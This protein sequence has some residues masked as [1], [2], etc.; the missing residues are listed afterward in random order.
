MVLE[1]CAWKSIGQHCPYVNNLSLIPQKYL[2]AAEPYQGHRWRSS[3]DDLGKMYDSATPNPTGSL[4]GP[5]IDDSAG[6]SGNVTGKLYNLENI[7]KGQTYI[8][9]IIS[10]TNW[11]D[12]L[13]CFIF[14][15][16]GWKNI[17]HDM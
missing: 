3:N 8:T 17:L 14:C 12:K 1:I 7:F 15:R 13:F 4:S 5:W 10:T 16:G 2:F 11:N 6:S 9:I